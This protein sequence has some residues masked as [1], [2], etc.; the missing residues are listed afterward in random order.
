VISSAHLLELR[1]L[2]IR[3]HW[4]YVRQ[5]RVSHLLMGVA[6]QLNRIA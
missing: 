6:R 5:R 2:P 3:A 1:S 4:Q